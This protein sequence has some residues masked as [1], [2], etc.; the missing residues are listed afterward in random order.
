MKGLPNGCHGARSSPSGFGLPAAVVTWI[1]F[2]DVCR[3]RHLSAIGIFG[4]VSKCFD[5]G[6]VGTV[7]SATTIDSC[8]PAPEAAPPSDN[9]QPT[10]HRED[11]RSTRAL[12]RRSNKSWKPAT[13][14]PAD[15]RR[16]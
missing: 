11:R 15:G 1:G 16:G 9:D 10:W 5:V 7:G 8:V 14:E 13:S 3:S 4:L 6:V 2:P 12:R